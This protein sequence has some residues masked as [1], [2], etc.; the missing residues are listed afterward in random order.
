M[1]DE[2]SALRRA[3]YG[4]DMDMLR[5]RQLV[6]NITMAT[7]IS[8]KQLKELRNN[9]WKKAFSPD[10]TLDEDISIMKNRKATIV[11]E[12]LIQASDV[13]HTMQHWHIYCKWN[14]RLYQECYFAY[15]MGRAEKD[16]SLMWYK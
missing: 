1:E 8:D 3:I 13:A 9:R 5:F 14:E 11:L 12:H 10:N 16:P 4:N 15:K 6:V 7:D 2:Y